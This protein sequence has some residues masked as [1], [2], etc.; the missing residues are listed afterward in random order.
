MR[1]ESKRWCAYQVGLAVE[2]RF[3]PACLN[4][5]I[6]RV[7]LFDRVDLADFEEDHVNENGNLRAKQRPTDNIRHH[8]SQP[9][10]NNSLW[11]RFFY[12][13]RD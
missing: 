6:S 1:D 7:R 2:R 10:T 11:L 3:S 9:T 8:R 12:S 5:Y 13:R 4:E